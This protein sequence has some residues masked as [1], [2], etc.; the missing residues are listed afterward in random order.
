MTDSMV[1]RVA[2]ALAA[3]EFDAY[4]STFP[5]GGPAKGDWVSSHWGRYT[6]HARAAIEAMR[7]PT[8][9]MTET[10][11]DAMLDCFP[12]RAITNLHA[13]RVWLP[14]IT[15]ALDDGTGPL[16]IYSGKP[17]ND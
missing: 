16:P 8:P 4:I 9:R 17:L 3:R 5:S 7:E 15:A 6:D 14:T 10:I 12:D 13:L 11:M 2:R 1:E